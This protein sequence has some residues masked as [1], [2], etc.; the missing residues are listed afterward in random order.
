M[1]GLL[2]SA[3]QQA[4]ETAART[5][6][7][8]NLKQAALALQQHHNDYGCL[9][10]GFR[11][12]GASPLPWSGWTLSALPYLEQNALYKQGLDAYAIT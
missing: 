1:M 12:F 8:N 4:R 10:P 9:P 11:S 3:V 7:Q 5:A 6:C 2:L